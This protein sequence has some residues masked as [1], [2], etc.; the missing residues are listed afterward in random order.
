[1]D[2]MVWLLPPALAFLTGV[3]LVNYLTVHPLVMSRYLFPGNP[4]M[5]GLVAVLARSEFSGSLLLAAG[6]ALAAFVA[7][8]AL[9]TRIFL[10]RDDPR[11]VPPL[12]RVPRATLD[13]GIRR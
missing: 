5:A 11:Q 7:G 2:W 4:G 9:M 3:L 8:Y 1:M 12:T 10:A 13:W 6:L